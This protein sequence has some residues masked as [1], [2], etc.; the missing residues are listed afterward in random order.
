MEGHED[1]FRCKSVTNDVKIQ[2]E[3]SDP[4]E[5]TTTLQLPV[6]NGG[7]N[8]G[9]SKICPACHPE[10]RTDPDH[11]CDCTCNSEKEIE[12]ESSEDDSS[13]EQPSVVRQNLL[14]PLTFDD[15]YYT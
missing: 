5:N 3:P 10:T 4:S 13:E 15:L 9:Q 2:I 7:L 8:Q 14:G 1:A 12:E 6:P 11:V